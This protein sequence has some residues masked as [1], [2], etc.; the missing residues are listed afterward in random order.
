MCVC[1]WNVEQLMLK[2]YILFFSFFL[3]FSL[4]FRIYFPQYGARTKPLLFIILYFSYFH[5]SFFFFFFISYSF[6]SFD[7]FMNPCGMCMQESGACVYFYVAGAFA[8]ASYYICMC[9]VN[10]SP[11][12]RFGMKKER[13]T[14]FHIIFSAL[15]HTYAPFSVSLFFFIVDLMR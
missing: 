15:R 7:V 11:N 6:H 10:T 5:S 9:V 13:K 2:V 4:F 1:T 8:K 14:I 12:F 3:F